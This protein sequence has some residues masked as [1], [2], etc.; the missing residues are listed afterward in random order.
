MV[1]QI[2]CYYIMNIKIKIVLIGLVISNFFLLWN[3][4]TQRIKVYDG[5]DRINIDVNSD[6]TFDIKPID[7]LKNVQ[8]VYCFSEYMCEECVRQDLCVLL[9]IQKRIGAD[10]ILILTAY[11]DNRNNHIRLSNLLR[12]FRYRNIDY[13]CLVFPKHNRTGMDQRYFYFI[14]K[15]GNCKYPFYPLKD[16][17]E[18]TQYYLGFIA[19]KIV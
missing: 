6:L 5:L 3:V 8:L 2:R 11:A 14:D 15:D 17:L 9:D 1:M 19:K 12:K 10:R 18:L 16:H 7:T 13:S 4:V